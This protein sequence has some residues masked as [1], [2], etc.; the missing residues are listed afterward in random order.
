MQLQIVSSVVPEEHHDADQ[1]QD[2]EEHQHEEEVELER[3]DDEVSGGRRLT[4]FCPEKL[5]LV[6]K[7][8]YP[9]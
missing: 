7:D 4:G 1:A 9:A 6:S 3:E 5:C 2:Y 8:F